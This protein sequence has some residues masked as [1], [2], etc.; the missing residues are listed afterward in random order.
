MSRK[1]LIRAT[2]IG[3]PERCL[4][5]FD[6]QKLVDT[7]DDWIFTRTGIR[8]RRIAE[9][10]IATSDL[11]IKAASQCLQKAGMDA[12]DL[13]LI[14]VATITPD[15]LCPATACQVQDGLGAKKAAA[16]DLCAACTG[17]VYALA[18]ASAFIET[19]MYRNALVIGAETLSRFVD[20]TDRRTCVLFG[21]GAG[22]VLVEASDGERGVLRSIL[23]ADG[24]ASSLLCVP[25]GGSRMPL[26]EQSLTQKLHYLRM[27]G[28]EV[29]KLGVHMFVDAVNEALEKAG[30]KL[31]DIDLFVSHQANL[32]IIEAA[33]KRLGIS[34]ERMMVNIDRY[35]NTS[36]ASIPI[37]LEEAESTGKLKPN[38][39]V[40]TI[41]FGAGFSWGTNLIRW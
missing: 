19:G 10:G 26:S 36:S 13:D 9:D 3:L 4:S 18:S 17:F 32:R 14:I 38:D 11:A 24:S 41:G 35:G 21:D 33:A 6:I 28:R 2:G 39:L 25:A 16:F 29:Y 30:L 1:A 37:A 12:A 31:D 34:M 8:Y 22:A 27:D 40:L 20:W 23:H 15:M 7:T 5:N